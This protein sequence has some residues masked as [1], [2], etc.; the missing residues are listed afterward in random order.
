MGAL[1]SAE[2][3][4]MDNLDGIYAERIDLCVYD[5]AMCEFAVSVSRVMRAC[6]CVCVSV[7]LCV[8]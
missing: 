3:R 5:K 6:L 7:C 4:W 8:E 1:Y 2:I